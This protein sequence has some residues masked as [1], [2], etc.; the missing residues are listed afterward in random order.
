M[1]V[2]KKGDNNE[3]IKEI[4]KVLGVEQVGNFG[5]KT[6]TAVKEFQKKHGLTA[7]GIVGPGTL[8]K[9]GL[10]APAAAPTSAPAPNN[11]PTAG[12]KYSKESIEKTVKAKGYKWFEGKDYLLNIVGVRNSDTGTK[13]TNAFD[14]K[15]TLSYQVNGEW[16]YK[17]WM[18]T[19]DPGTKGVKEYHNAA[20]VA[21]LVPGQYIDSHFLGKHQGKYEALKQIGKVKVYRDANR[22][23]NYDEKVIQ[24]GVF[25][26][27]IH[28]AGKDSTYVENW[29]EG[30]QVFKRE[31]DFNE[32][33]DIVRKSVAGGNSKFTYTLIESKD[34]K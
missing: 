20:G 7:D 15:I 21:R 19:T 8:A 10:T 33:M 12:A 14:D 28:K 31:A 18:N 17:E 16:I 1:A 23:M 29:S 5:P 13:V 32:F 27:N 25:G 2:Y 4:Q 22:D 34:I 11:K 24:E 3:F 30:C 26:I 6:E 9:M